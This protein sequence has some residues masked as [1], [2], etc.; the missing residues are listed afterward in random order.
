MT[1][2]ARLADAL[3]EGRTP[4]APLLTGDLPEMADTPAAPAAVLIAVTDRAMPG[5]ILTQRT[6][7]LRSHAG[8]VAFPGGRIDPDDAGPVAAALREAEEEIG[9]P[10]GVPDVIG[11]ADAYHTRTGYIVTPVIAVVPPDLQFVPHEHEVAAIFEV[12]LAHLLNPA[13]RVKRQATFKGCQ[14]SY[15]EIMWDGRRI[16]GVTAAIIVNLARR[17]ATI[18]A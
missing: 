9:L 7:T 6:A 5:V 1:L 12:P 18:S 16:W 2:A 15:H 11:I 3:R 13:K 14:V 17:L 10:R 8:Q 4:I